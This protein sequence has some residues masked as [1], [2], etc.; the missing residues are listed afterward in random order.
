MMH[1][2]CGRVSHLVA[3]H[4]L[5]KPVPCAPAFDDK[6]RLRWCRKQDLIIANNIA[7]GL[8]GN[9][10]KFW[11]EVNKKR[12]GHG[13]LPV[14]MQGIS[15]TQDIAEQWSAHFKQLYNDP[16]HPNISS[17]NMETSRQQSPT[18]KINNIVNAIKI[19]NKNS[20]QGHDGITSSH[21]VHAHPVLRVMLSL[22]FTLCFSHV[23]TP[24][25]MSKVIITPIV[26]A[27]NDDLK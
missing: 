25:M 14:T 12:K 18:V 23:H 7:R 24:A 6:R 26:K 1:V 3:A 10:T 16:N 11:S 20:S 2:S 17:Y 22:L 8:E 5:L 4:S 13:K 27:K 9:N 21:I 15:G 19:L